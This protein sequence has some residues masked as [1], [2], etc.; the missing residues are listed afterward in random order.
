MLK[1][2][3]RLRTNFTRFACRWVPRRGYDGRRQTASAASN[4]CG[5]ATR[6]KCKRHELNRAIRVLMSAGA[7]GLSAMAT[8]GSVTGATITQ[9]Q[10]AT[11]YTGAFISFSVAKV[12]NPSCSS[13][14]NWSF[15]LPLTTTLENQMLALMLAARA[16]DSPVTF[17][18]SGV[19]DQFSTVETLE[20]VLY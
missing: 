8:A 17:I 4:A 7:I 20:Y 14:P 5:Q 12:S 13:N 10:I 18:G 15:F 9:I 3:I 2:S 11:N 6:T 1:M 16:S 19:C